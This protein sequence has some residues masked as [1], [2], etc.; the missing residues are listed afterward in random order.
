MENK[1]EVK[2][3]LEEIKKACDEHLKNLENNVYA[4]EDIVGWPAHF[5]QV[6]QDVQYPDL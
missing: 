1:K 3:N 6:L 5:S 2:E 4:E